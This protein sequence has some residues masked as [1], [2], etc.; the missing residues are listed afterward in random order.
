M[1][2]PP[3]EQEQAAPGETYVYDGNGDV[4]DIIYADGSSKKHMQG[5]MDAQ[6]SANRYLAGVEQNLCSA[7]I[8]EDRN[9]N[10]IQSRSRAYRSDGCR[11]ESL[12]LVVILLA[13]WILRH[14]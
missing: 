13:H 3:V 1:P 7:I 2:P 8:F 12:G 4:H 5:V 9:V 14:C 11:I 10:T 6:L